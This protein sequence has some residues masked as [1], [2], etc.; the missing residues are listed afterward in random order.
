MSESDTNDT[1]AVWREFW[2]PIVS[3]DGVIDMEQIKKELWD[4]KQ[5]MRSAS[6]VYDHVT[7]SR[8]TNVLTVPDAVIG[9]ADEWQ[10]EARLADI[11]AFFAEADFDGMD[12]DTVAGVKEYME[13]WFGKVPPIPL[14]QDGRE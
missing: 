4:F 2:L 7:R 10:Q 1:E 12:K 11:E 3:K 5:L 14:Y 13:R 8:V 9:V 6:I